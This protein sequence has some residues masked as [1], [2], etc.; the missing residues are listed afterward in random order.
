MLQNVLDASISIMPLRVKVCAEM[1]ANRLRR[2]VVAVLASLVMSMAFSGTAAAEG[3]WAQTIR[4]AEFWSGPD[5]T[6]RLFGQLPRGTYVLVVNAGP[7]TGNTRLFAREAGEQNFGYIEAVTL[8]PTQA[9]PGEMPVSPAHPSAFR[10]FWAATLE[11]TNLQNGRKN[12]SE[13]VA[14]LPQFTKI[15]VLGD[16][17]D[18]HYYV[19]DARTSRVGYLDGS[20]V[21]PSQAPTP[22]DEVIW[23]SPAFV[24]VP[25]GH[26]PWWVKAIRATN[27][28]SAISDG[29]SFGSVKDGDRF[30]VMEPLAG[31]RLTIFNPVTRNFAYIDLDAVTKTGA[32][33][34]AAVEVG[35]W[36]GIVSGERANLRQEPHT[37]MA[38]AGQVL[39]G[40]EVTISSW[41]E[42][43][44]LEAD[45]RTWARVMGVRR[46][47]SD[48][49]WVELPL[50]D[51]SPERYV[52][53][54]LLV[55]K[56]V[57]E[58]PVPPTMS[59]GRN[60]AK[61][62]D[63]NI[64]HQVFVAYEGVTR[65]YMAALTSGRPGWSTPL[66][67]FKVLR[68]V[69]NETML[70]STLFRVDSGEV[71]DY[72]LENVKW[73]QYFTSGGAA[74]HTNYWRSPVLFGIPSSH[75]C[76][77]MIERH[78]K[79]LWDWAN[80]GTPINIHN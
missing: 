21:G 73:T 36:V 33:K 6:A 42:G 20:K 61:W 59:L 75:G 54:G 57:T 9:P 45:N 3:W 37:V 25:D 38:S 70:G 24:T 16:P 51:I 27:L 5:A 43:E 46:K 64:T 22:E 35:G 74:L 49:T 66:G 2:L 4:P 13:V 15:M 69:E 17:G 14:A 68:R 19:Q 40:D 58:A 44:E 34:P 47:A 10:P 79:W 53:S 41:V 77:G 72:K 80:V 18:G 8:N 50:G 39:R 76:L 23:S 71:P 63:V 7:E 26:R 31:A 32:P 60:G 78:A 52:Y 29:V 55:A 48:G 62:I 11:A 28:W 1:E 67:V 65:V 56:V 30:L 12:S